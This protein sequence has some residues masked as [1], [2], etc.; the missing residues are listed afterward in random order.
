MSEGALMSNGFDE[1]AMGEIGRP[2]VTSWIRKSS[3]LL[4]KKL[5][6]NDCVWADSSEN[7]H[8]NGVYIP[9]EIR[10]SGLFPA[11]INTNADKPHIF[12]V[13]VPTLWPATAEVRDSRFVHYSNK[14]T[15]MHLTRVPKDQFQGLSPASW[16]VGGLL[17]SPVNGASYWFVTLDSESA[18]AELLESLFDLDATFHYGLFNPADVLR[19][20][21]DE[22][23]R[24][25]EEL[26]TAIKQ[27]T[28]DAFIRRVEILPSPA[29]FAANAQQAF[30]ESNHMTDLNPYRISEPGNALMTISRDIEYAL[31]KK[32]ER[33]H[34]AAE[35]VR[36][37]TEQGSDL[38]TAVVRG[39]SE[40]D[41]NFLSASQHRKSRA[42]YSFEQHIGRM[43]H[44]GN[45]PFEAQVVTG[46][47]RPDFILPSA[48]TFKSTKR[49]RDEALIISAKTTLRE[50]WKQ[51]ALEK[52]NCDLFLA[53]VDDRVSAAAVDEMEALGIKIVVPEALKSADECC[54]KGKSNVISFREFFDEDIAMR[55]RRFWMP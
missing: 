35:V 28:L 13:I 9:R 34:R 16:F 1:Q 39:F 37:L 29:Q 51:I 49:T 11:L 43:L 36:I 2:I 17:K 54:Y 6:R 14:G 41:A 21:Q 26:L 42:G 47:R 18:E 40:L 44:D 30:L 24:L 8:Q 25:I 53:T 12:E 33:R 48:K 55:Q 31:Y 52:L 10:E 32:A 7:G 4:L 19:V 27:G 5:S 22:T 46:S 15:E 38:V 20:E 23:E 50:R 3:K 45:I